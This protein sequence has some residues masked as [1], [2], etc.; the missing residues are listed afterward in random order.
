MFKLLHH[1]FLRGPNLVFPASGLLLVIDHGGDGAQ[2]LAW[3]P[4]TS[5]L[6]PAL[7]L[8][9]EAFPVVSESSELSSPDYICESKVPIVALLLA[10]AE[11]IMRDYCT[12]PRL[13]RL[14]AAEQRQM[15]VFLPCD[16]AAIGMAAWTLSVEV[17]KTIPSF[18]GHNQSWLLVHLKSHYRDARQ[19]IYHYGLNQSTLALARSVLQR[20]IPHY[21]INM[22]GQFLQLGHG[23]HRKRV[24]ET[25]TDDTSSVGAMISRDKF[26][27]ASLLRAQGLPTPH[28][29]LVSSTEEAL[30]VAKQLG[31]PVVVKPRASGKGKGVTVNIA[32]EAEL[33]TAIRAAAAYNNGVIVERH[34]KGDDHRLLVVGGRFIAAAKRFPAEV[35]GD[36][37]HTVSQLVAELNRDPRRGIMPFERLLEKVDI[38]QEAMKHLADAGL[39]PDSIPA[40]G[41][42]VRL[43]G[44]ANLSR[45]G[46]SIDVTEQIHPDNR[47]MAERAARLVGLDVTGID[48]LTP[49]IGQ[50][51]RDIP[52]AILELNTT[53][54]LRPHLAANPKRDVFGPIIEHLF[55]AC[56]DGRVPTVGITGSVGKT[57]T[58]RMVASILSAS[59]KLVALS[60]TQGAWVGEDTVRIGDVA[61]GG[62][63]STLLLDPRVE[64]GVFELS[65]GGLIKQGMTLDALDVGAVLNVYDNHLGLD[66]VSSQEDLARVKRLVVENARRMAVLNADDPLCLAMREFVTAPKLCLVSAASDNPAV[67]AHQDAGGVVAYLDRS[68]ANFELRLYEGR[69]CIGSMP[70][71]EIPATWGGRYR[72]GMINALFAMAVAHGTGVAF[73]TIRAALSSFQSTHDTNPGRMNF[74][75]NLPYQLCITWAD[76]PVTMRELARFIDGLEVLGRKRL[77]FCSM[78]NRPDSFIVD[79]A[80]SVAVAF[81]DYICYDWEDLRG[82]PAG[83]AVGLLARG[84]REGGV[85]DEQITLAASHDE[86][87]DLALARPS[88]GDLLVVVTFGAEK[89]WQKAQALANC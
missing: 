80:I 72:P 2:P 25:A 53:P 44:V 64:A 26:K 54:G 29:Q 21:R 66:G 69:H 89:A 57:T 82:R 65:R 87:L 17:A 10:T 5:D 56:S 60:T 30:R 18:S 19:T 9:L 47:L 51:W 1:H 40:A 38:D 35:T 79:M 68:G 58:C 55:P 76:G 34:I 52:C 31:F 43:R 7:C 75:E 28:T 16:E 61:G 59:G 22:P 62:T 70:G 77:M 83:E 33:M 49:D 3:R 81:T 32:N 4:A 42:K 23:R 13:G 50:S 8:L 88:A 37:R 20:G 36:G 15:R 85:A 14:L 6:A 27:T 63:A 41:Q 12:Q 11:I 84:L 71:A 45:G 24:M 73:D 86:A 46:T 74:V 39:T 48:F 67:Q 78:G